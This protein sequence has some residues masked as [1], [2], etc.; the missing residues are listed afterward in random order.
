EWTALLEVLG[1]P[2]RFGD[3]VFGTP[4]GRRAEH[5]R[6]DAL[7]SEATSLHEV[8]YLAKLL[9]SNGVPA[10]KVAGGSDYLDDPQLSHRQ[11]YETLDHDVAG[12][13][14]YQGWPMRFS[15]G[16]QRSHR[17]GTPTLGQHNREILCGELGLGDD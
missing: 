5:D 7:L 17:S 2:D 3:P 6:L 12:P 11:Y 16:P 4:A 8:A 10:A 15:I 14:R 1:D 13:D 9:T